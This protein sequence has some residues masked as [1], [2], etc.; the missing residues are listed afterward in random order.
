MPPVPRDAR[1][2][3]A[4][5]SILP[6]GST[7]D[8]VRKGFSSQPISNRTPVIKTY[9]RTTKAEGNGLRTPDTRRNKW[10]P[11]E[12][13]D[14]PSVLVTADE[15]SRA[16]KLL[17]V[18]G[19]NKGSIS[20]PTP[21][22]QHEKGICSLFLVSD[23]CNQLV[24]NKIYAFGAPGSFSKNKQ[25]VIRCCETATIFSSGRVVAMDGRSLHHLL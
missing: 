6:A 5:L 12:R 17:R 2:G 15:P 24:F 11:D 13:S 20:R 3:G 23:A 8:T 19:Q 14:K 10:G 1:S 7:T 16:C 25:R 21:P 9:T 18:P 22:S 4:S